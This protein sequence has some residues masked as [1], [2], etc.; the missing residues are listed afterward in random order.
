[1]IILRNREY[2]RS[3]QEKLARIQAKKADKAEREIIKEYEKAAESMK[4]DIEVFYAR[5]AKT[6]DI[7]MAEA[8]KQL[9]K[10]EL[11]GWRLTLDEF[12]EKALSDK[13]QFT[14]ELDN[15]YIRSRVSRLEALRAQVRHNIDILAETG[16]DRRKYLKKRV[17][18]YI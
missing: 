10:S 4:R 6:N 1:M 13:G 18:R 12:R 8:R 5:Y 7:S 16:K 9:D 15:E 2:W 3:R 17:Q 11:K 14:Q